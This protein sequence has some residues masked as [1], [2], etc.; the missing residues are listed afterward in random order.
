MENHSAKRIAK[1][2]LTL[3]KRNVDALQPTDRP[4]IAWDDKISGFG[5]RVQPSGTRT[6]V[7]NYRA[8]DGGRKAPNKRVTLG[9]YGRITP[10]KARRMAQE[11]LGRVAGGDDPASERAEARRMPT[12]QEAF[13]DYMAAN[14]NRKARTVERY[15][16]NMRINLHGWRNRPLDAIAR[17][18]IEGRFNL[19]TEEHGWAGANQTIS[20]L[21]SIY[22]RSCVDHEG[23]RNP[24]E[25]WLAG[26]GRYHPKRRRRIS[27]PS[28]VLPRW[29]AGVDAV[30]LPPAHRDIFLVGVYTGM[31]LGEIVSLRWERLELERRILRV[32]ETKTGEPLELPMTRQ[33][34]AIFERRRADGEDPDGWV[35]PSSMSSTGH[36]G[37]IH[38]YYVD[39]G[40]AA[41]TRFWFHGL[42]NVFITVAERE[43]ML[44]RSLTK[45][46]VNHAR[47]S[48]VTESYAAE[49][50]VEQLREPAQRIADRIDELAPAGGSGVVAGG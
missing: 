2:K 8:G 14:P 10:D 27:A 48:D 50:T 7:V 18:D 13:D 22:R 46:L 37:G 40:R 21:R 43:L 49:W 33:L 24:V 25:L 44:P 11:L 34:A 32:E 20:L 12:L 29:R 4:W 47:R 16:Q 31:R 35:F 19:I 36:L 1:V 26:G 23:L 30:G 5:V 45:R 17:R 9:R 28:E 15:H 41:G 38:Q 6:F 39:I 3:T 42:R